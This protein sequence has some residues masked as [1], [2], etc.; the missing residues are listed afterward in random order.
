M[1][2]AFAAVV[3]FSVSHSTRAE[4]VLG[5]TELLLEYDCVRSCECGLS[6]SADGLT[7]YFDG[8]RVGAADSDLY[9]KSRPS[10]DAQWGPTVNL[11][12]TVNTAACEACPCISADGLELYYSG[13]PAMNEDEPSDIWVTRRISPE[14]PWE[15]PERLGSV[16]NTPACHEVEPCL[17]S[18]GLSLYFASNQNSSNRQRFDIWVSTRKAKNELW[19]PAVPLGPAVNAGGAWAPSLSANGLVLFFSSA[20]PGGVAS[21]TDI[22]MAR[23]ASLLD[24]WTEPVCVSPIPDSSTCIYLT[25]VSADGTTLYVTEGNGHYFICQAPILPIADFDGSGSVGYSDMLILVE[26][27]GSSDSWCDIGPTP[28]GDGVVDNADLEVLLS[29]WDE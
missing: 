17:S 4:F 19:E 8:H 18:D 13:L 24:P 21:P 26:Q 16:I 22:W 25:R 20:R 1:R 2:A 3:V 15:P 28:L 5:S 12:P 11:G 14:T 27:W 10:T 9:M 7:V 29:Y 23:R 6:M